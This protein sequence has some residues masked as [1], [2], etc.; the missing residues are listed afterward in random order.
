MKTILLSLL[1]SFPAH[2]QVKL[3][4]ISK[5]IVI[6]RTIEEVFHHVKNT[7]N[8]DTWRTEVNSMEADG[9]FALGTTYIEDAHIGLQRNFITK[10]VLVNIVEN[11]TAFYVT[12]KNAKYFLSSLRTVESI[13]ED[14]T[15]FT[16]TVEFDA[17][18][19]KETL[20]ILLPHE[21][22]AFSYGIIMGQYLKNLKD[23][24]E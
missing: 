16:Y 11:D 14:Q 18:M 13:G 5:S 24:L 7:L 17:M 8:D 6:N 23:Y 15:K 19:S 22:L 3:V 1:V 2:S 4:H 21:V 12:P 9:P 10:T 20:M